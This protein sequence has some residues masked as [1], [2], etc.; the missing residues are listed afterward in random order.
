MDVGH[1]FP[2]IVHNVPLLLAAEVG[3]WGGGVW[4]SL[5]ALGV[6]WIIRFWRAGNMWLIVGLCAWLGLV[7][8]G[9]LDYYPWALE[10][11]R[12]LTMFIWAIIGRNLPQEA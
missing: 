3:V 2:D 4:F 6:W 12:L 9:M 11:G 1:P 5:A 8:E 7:G 10:T